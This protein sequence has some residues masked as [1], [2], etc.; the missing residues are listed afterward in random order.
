[1]DQVYLSQTRNQV[2][3]GKS[4]RRE[5]GNQVSQK[6]LAKKNMTPGILHQISVALFLPPNTPKTPKGSPASAFQKSLGLDANF[7]SAT[8]S[9]SAPTAT[10]AAELRGRVSRSLGR[11]RVRLGGGCWGGGVSVRPGVGCGITTSGTP[12]QRPKKSSSHV[13][14]LSAHRLC[15]NVRLNPEN[16]STSYCPKIMG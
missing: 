12:G 4:L 8:T 9:A 13:D 16:P 2:K 14:G 10:P 11:F 6:H 3:H 1:M 5:T 7:F 15:F